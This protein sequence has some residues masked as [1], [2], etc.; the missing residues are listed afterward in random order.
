MFIFKPAY[1]WQK[2]TE[3]K[4]NGR[5]RFLQGL[6]LGLIGL[7]ASLKLL[8]DN[9]AKT[10]SSAN[11]NI[12]SGKTYNWKLVTTWP[13][14]FPILGEACTL[15]SKWVDTMSAGRLKIQVF[16]G[17]ELVPALECFD[18]VRRGAAEMSHGAAYYWAGKTSAAQFFAS[19]PFGMNAQQFNSWLIGGEGLQLWQELYEPFNL[20]PFPGG[21]SGVQMGG[22]FNK[23][24]NT[25]E[26]F[27]GLKMR[28]P[29]LGG[30]VL[31][32]IGASPVLISGGELYTSLERGV[33]DATEWMGPFHDYKMGFHEIAKYYYFPGWHETGTQLEFTVNKEKY[34]S[35]PADLQEIVRSACLRVNDWLLYTLEYQNALFLEKIKNETEVEIRNFPEEVLQSLR[36]AASKEIELIA[37]KD[38]ISKKIYGSYKAFRARIDPW[39]AVSE[40]MYYSVLN[41]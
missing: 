3:H 4:K 32:K 11:R 30:K 33:I 1:K 29:G 12:S 14:N 27:K 15:F 18:A 41:K 6:G 22:W 7:P 26:D 9:P 23:E 36:V 17:G 31:S 25:I 8:L 37:N 39:S 2:M 40:R 38:A 20:I 35:L 13:P 28:M 19:V 34:Q 10:S 21:N 5:L 16:G 24:I